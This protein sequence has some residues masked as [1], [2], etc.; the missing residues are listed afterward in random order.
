MEAV[1]RHMP[2]PDAPETLGRIQVR[3]RRAAGS[4]AH[5]GIPGVQD[6][7]SASLHRGIGRYLGTGGLYGPRTMHSRCAYPCSG[8]A[9]HALACSC[10]TE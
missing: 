3:R 6:T 9:V 4:V 8:L 7:A 2:V 5:V 1:M 10:V